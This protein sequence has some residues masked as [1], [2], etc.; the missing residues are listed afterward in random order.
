LQ[1]TQ[2]LSFFGT[3]GVISLAGIIINNEWRQ[4]PQNLLQLAGPTP[5]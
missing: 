1:A 3:L 2:P 4:S 5:P